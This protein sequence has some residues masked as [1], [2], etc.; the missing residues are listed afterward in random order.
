[1]TINDLK[2]FVDNQVKL[3]NGNKKILLS[4]DDEGNG[5]H[6]MYFSFTPIEEILKYGDFASGYI[7]ESIPNG[8]NIKDYI[9]LG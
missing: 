9:V 1:M 2:K 8:E 6:V 3:G 5:Y 4:D 7:K